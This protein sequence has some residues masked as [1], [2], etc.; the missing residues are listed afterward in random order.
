M[1][2]A[3]PLSGF[4]RRMLSGG[5]IVDQLWGLLPEPARLALGDLRQYVSRHGRLP[6]LEPLR[7]APFGPAPSAGVGAALGALVAGE[8]LSMVNVFAGELRG[9]QLSI[10]AA[11]VGD[12]ID[13]YAQGL[14]LVVGDVRGGLVERVNAIVGHVHGGEVRTIN[15]LIGDVHGGRVQCHA[16]IGDVHGGE[17]RARHHHGAVHG[18]RIDLERPRDAGPT[19]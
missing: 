2:M 13:G 3:S 15:L 14:A 19:R 11:L 16:L 6:K 7:R 4:A 10:A 8:K 12:V 18:G 5:L 1:R 9:G 17:V